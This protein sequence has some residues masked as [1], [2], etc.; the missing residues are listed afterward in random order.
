MYFIYNISFIKSAYYIMNNM[1]NLSQIFKKIIFIFFTASLTYYKPYF[2]LFF[3]IIFLPEYFFTLNIF[4]NL[5]RNRAD[6]FD[7]KITYS[8]LSNLSFFEIWIQISKLYSFQKVYSFFLKK[9]LQPYTI[10]LM[11]VIYIFNVPFKFLKLLHYF[12]IINQK[13]L[14]DGLEILYHNLYYSL[15]NCKI[16]ILN[17]KIYLNCFTLGKLVRSMLVGHQVSEQQAFNTLVDL[18]KIAINYK[19]Y[20]DKKPNFVDLKMTRVFDK[21]GKII[22]ES[23]PAHLVGLRSIHATSN[24]NFNLTQDQILINPMPSLITKKAINPGS[25]ITEKIVSFQ[26]TPK[27]IWIP[28]YELNSIKFDYEEAFPLEKDERVY[29]LCKEKIYID[30][31]QSNLNVTPDI[32]LV[33]ELKSNLYTIT[34]INASNKEFVAE[35]INFIQ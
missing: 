33:K 32:L 14:K 27:K 26:Q 31:L 12:L 34:L 35:I 25:I 20:E 2:I 6:Y 1:K 11:F 28:A 3:F 4:L 17:K 30:A 8:D 18:K 29:Q 13:S 16:E 7:V 19:E 15:K 22:Y 23:H 5:F 9:K 10:F 24:Q 21:N